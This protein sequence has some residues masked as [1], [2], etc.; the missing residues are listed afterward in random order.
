LYYESLTDEQNNE[1][2]SRYF[3][4][5]YVMWRC[6]YDLAYNA[7]VEVIGEVNR[8]EVVYNDT[9]YS[10]LTCELITMHLLLERGYDLTFVPL[11]K[12]L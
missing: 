12:D 10:T 11:I 2:Y 4:I 1:L 5:G 3:A 7:A 9:T 6:A 8:R